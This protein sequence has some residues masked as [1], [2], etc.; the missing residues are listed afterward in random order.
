[1][2]IDNWGGPGTLEGEVARI[3]PWGFTKYSAL[4][5]EE[6]R[7]RVTIRFTGPAEDRKG[8]GH[9]FRVE[10]KIVTWEAAEALTVP[11]SSL[12]RV[13]GD[14]AV[15]AVTAD[16][17]AEQ[18]LVRVEA[19]NGIDAAIADG[20]TAGDR[21]VLYPSATLTDGA[22]VAQRAVEG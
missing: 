22:R 16:G 7:V 18:R 4:G 11:S 19:N 3:E 14:W 5:V 13:G 20:F 9:G 15:F 1:V 8:L 2:I 17:R 10:V 6:Q 21:I 12:F